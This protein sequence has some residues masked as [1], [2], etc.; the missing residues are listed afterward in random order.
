M[1]KFVFVIASLTLP[2]ILSG[3]DDETTIP[4]PE[5]QY[6][7]TWFSEEN[8]NN[9][10]WFMVI[11]IRTRNHQAVPAVKELGGTYYLPIMSR[12]PTFHN[13]VVSGKFY[14]DQLHGSLKPDTV[15]EVTAHLR[16]TVVAGWGS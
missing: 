1:K 5:S 8:Q 4:K 16:D 13:K 6:V 3:C 14:I 2:F 15:F 10:D 9:Q 12:M 11:D 7:I